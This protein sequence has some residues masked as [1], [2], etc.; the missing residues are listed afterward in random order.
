MLLLS[1]GKENIYAMHS[2]VLSFVYETDIGKSFI[3]KIFALWMLCMSNTEKLKSQRT[4]ATPGF[5]DNNKQ[6]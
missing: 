5:Y 2:L 3:V 4:E 1:G 6:S